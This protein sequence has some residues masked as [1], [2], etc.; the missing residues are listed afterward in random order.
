KTIRIANAYFVPDN[1]VIDA[2]VDACNR[3]VDIEIIMPYATDSNLAI[4]ASTSRWGPLLANGCKI[5]R[6]KGAL[7]H[8]KVFIV[9]DIW[10]SVGSSNFDTRSFRLND[11][12][13]INVLDHAWALEQLDLFEEDKKNCILVKLEDWRN[14]PRLEKIRDRLAA[15][16]RSQL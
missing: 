7:Y 10:V 15:L 9:D 1:F 4:Y 5:Y 11:E 14:R 6:Y 16:A 8:C 3:G 13:N 12:M 2:L